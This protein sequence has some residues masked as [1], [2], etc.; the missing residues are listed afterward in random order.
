VADLTGARGEQRWQP[1]PLEL[2]SLSEIRLDDLLDELRARVRQVSADRERLSGL[3]DAVVGIGRDLDLAATLQR[4]V[5]AACRL[6]GARYGAL[7]VIGPDQ[8]LV[9]FVTD[10]LS[11]VE[12]EAIGALPTGRGV[13][14]LL[15][16]DPSPL[17]L[18]EVSEH[19]ASSGFPPGHPPMHSFLGVPV[20]IRDQVFGNLY[21]ADK[22]DGDGFTA[23][24]EEVVGALAT[25][26]GVA[27]ENA[28]LYSAARR[29]QRWLEATAEIIE[30][31]LGEVRRTA[32][33]QLVARRAREVAEA[34]LVLVL[35]YDEETGQLTV[36]VV[37]DGE[38]PGATHPLRGMVLPLV[39]TAFHDVVTGDRRVVVDDLGKAA[40]WTLPVHTGATLLAPLSAAGAILGVLAV[41]HASPDAFRDDAEAGLLTTFARQAA[42][43]LERARALEERE[44]LVV[45]EDRERIARDLHDVVIQ[46]LF[47]T[48]LQLQ[49]VARLAGRPDLT[50][51]INSTVDE[52]DNTI[53]EIRSAIFELRTPMASTLRADIRATIDAA[54]A[55]LGFRPD[56]RL[57]GPIDS[58]V[59]DDLRPDLL[60]VLSETLSNAVRHARASAVSVVVQV[61]D[62]YVTVVVADNGV[63]GGDLDERGGL[64]NLRQRAVRHGGEFTISPHHPAGTR[65]RWSV[66]IPD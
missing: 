17:R 14:G 16:S 32:D 66:P 36:E 20:R 65:I 45:L 57:D 49:S 44:M 4:I 62:G 52:L 26:A 12:R 18:A 6:A 37:D 29:R 13:L 43:A 40:D 15:I 28:R 39:G 48:G 30:A 61:A 27:I 60:A 2:G 47:A 55:S 24:D 9:E 23:A 38:R 46:R 59:P 7:G 64:L 50:D 5:A 53:R 34:T 56:L 51:R 19:P 31:L 22:I 3:L 8:R 58:A 25:A 63:G 11:D 41:A 54:A 21:L 35:L 10:G 33:L 42:L 1:A